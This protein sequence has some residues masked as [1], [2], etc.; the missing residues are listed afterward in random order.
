MEFVDYNGNDVNIYPKQLLINPDFQIWKRGE[1]ISFNDNDTTTNGFKYFADMWCTYFE[2][3]V[4]NNY[5]FEK[6]Y[7]GVK[8]TCSR[9]ISFSQFMLETLDS[10]KNYTFVASI[11]G[12]VHTLTFK[13][14][15]SKNSELL[16]YMNKKDTAFYDRLIIRVKN[17]DIVNYANLFEGD[18]I[19]PHIKKL[20]EED[21]NIC[22]LYYRIEYINTFIFFR[23]NN[24]NNE[25]KL[26]GAL[27]KMKNNTISIDITSSYSIGNDSNGNSM[28]GIRD[29]NAN[30]TMIDCIVAFQRPL[31]EN[32]LG[33][34][35]F[36][37]ISCEP[38]I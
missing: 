34:L 3:G 17:N 23:Y 31:H 5:T 32:C 26:V 22:N 36:A 28:T 8:V 19:Y 21:Y 25:I 24:S 20:Y 9:D 33:V 27:P 13:G 10:N 1:S 29:I 6:V 38:I 15:E 30:G 11:N 7:N 14:Q 12:I 16:Q 2:R 4:G 35:L 37:K 18:S